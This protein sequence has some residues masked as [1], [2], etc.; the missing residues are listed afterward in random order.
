MSE[1]VTLTEEPT[2]QEWFKQQVP[3][4]AQSMSALHSKTHLPPR[5]QWSG[6]VQ[7]LGRLH[8]SR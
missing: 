4:S 3:G 8:A 5:P 6:G 2:A 7:S 1:S